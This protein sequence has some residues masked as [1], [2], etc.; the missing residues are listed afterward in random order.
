MSGSTLIVGAPA[1]DIGTDADAGAVYVFEHTGSSWTQ[2]ARLVAPV[3]GVGARFGSSVAIRGD[4]VVVGSNDSD[5][6]S[7]ST[8]GEVNVYRRVANAWT[9]HATLDPPADAPGDFGFAVAVSDTEDRIGVTAPYDLVHDSYHGVA[10]AYAFDGVHWLPALTVRARPSVPPVAQDG[11]GWNVAF[12]GNE[13]VIGAPN[14]GDGAVYV[15]AASEG[16]FADG[17][18]ASP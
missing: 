10:Y 6:P 8:Y 15:G 18:E 3:T 7:A 1:T 9:W 13:F 5:V 11:F 2:R 14:D 4:T 12:V 16:I 17:F